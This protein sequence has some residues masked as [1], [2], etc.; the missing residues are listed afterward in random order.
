MNHLS[1]TEKTILFVETIIL[2]TFTFGQ[3]YQ[4][5]T[6]KYKQT[7][8]GCDGASGITNNEFVLISCGVAARWLAIN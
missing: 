7:G 4:K 8:S 6:A 2:V 5:G 1:I 3:S